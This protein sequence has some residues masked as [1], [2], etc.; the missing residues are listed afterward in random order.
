MSIKPGALKPSRHGI[1]TYLKPAV[2][3]G[4]H[5]FQRSRT[6]FKTLGA[7]R[8]TYSTPRIHK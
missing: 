2:I 6:H 5:I 4:A 3:Q 8:V 7:R 1:L